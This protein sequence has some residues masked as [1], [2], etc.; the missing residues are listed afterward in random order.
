MEEKKCFCIG[1]RDAVSSEIDGLDREIL[2]HIEEHGVTEFIVGNY[3]NFDGLVA[4]AVLRAKKKYPWVRLT[5]LLPYHPGERRVELPPGFDG[6]L[7][8]D[9]MEKVPRRLAI[10]RANLRAVDMAQYM[11]AFVWHPASNSR[12]IL[13]YA[14]AREKKGGIRV[15]VLSRRT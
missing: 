11:I 5:L 13:A 1:H 14:R 8:P 12:E 4:A 3:G 15:C 2:R 6:S 10:I 9:G 7:Y